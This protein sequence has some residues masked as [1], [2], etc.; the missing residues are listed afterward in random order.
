MATSFVT[1]IMAGGVGSRMG[2]KDKHKVCFE[3]L[4]VPV[5]N[6]ALETY[7][8]C[9]ASLNLIVV[10]TMAE[11]VMST[12]NQRFPGTA[13]AFQEKQLGTG[14]ATRKGAEILERM[15]FDGDVLVVAGDKLI[16]PNIIRGLLKEHQKSGADVTIA[17]TKRESGSSAGLVLKN[18]RGAIQKII[19]TSEVHRLSAIADLDHAL[20]LLWTSL[21]DFDG[22]YDHLL[23]ELPA[24]EQQRATRFRIDAARHRFVLGRTVLRRHL[25]TSLGMDPKALAF[26]T[27]DRGKPHLAFSDIDDRSATSR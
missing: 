13:F 12:V 15:R 10:G 8:L 4:G 2:S 18:R 25:S 20:Q 14:D 23:A 24:E 11:K 9:G 6:R 17:T 19:E 3:V 5:I 21:E 27:S 7:N 22:S 16:E 26:S 1:M